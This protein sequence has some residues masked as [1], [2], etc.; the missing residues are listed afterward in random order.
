M[1]SFLQSPNR[2][3]NLNSSL[4]E[5]HALHRWGASGLTA[6]GELESASLG[7]LARNLQ[8]ELIRILGRKHKRML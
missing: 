5:L 3:M 1:S 8:A 2:Y 6:L 4:G 7:E